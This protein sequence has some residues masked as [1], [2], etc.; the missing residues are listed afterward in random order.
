MGE[1]A[2]RKGRLRRIDLLRIFF[3]SFL[4]QASWNYRGM[5]NLGFLFTIRPGLSRLF[6]REEDRLAAAVR[7]AGFFNTHPYMASYAIGATLAAEE[8]LIERGDGDVDDFAAASRVLAPPHRLEHTKALGGDQPDPRTLCGRHAPPCGHGPGHNNA[9]CRIE[10]SM[11]P[12]LWGGWPTQAEAR[13]IT[14][15]CELFLAAGVTT[16]RRGR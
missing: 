5:L 2:K 3:R 7:H 4:I 1:T 15:R 13:M 16:S 14:G 10:Q 6:D 9:R 8:E 11:G 12:W